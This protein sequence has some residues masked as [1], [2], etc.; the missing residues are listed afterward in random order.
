[1]VLFKENWSRDCYMIY[2]L[3]VVT[4]GVTGVKTWKNLQASPLHYHIHI[5]EHTLVLFQQEKNYHTSSHP[6][7]AQHKICIMRECLSN[8]TEVDVKLS[9]NNNWL[10]LVSHG[11]SSGSTMQG[12]NAESCWGITVEATV[13][14]GKFCSLQIIRNLPQYLHSHISN[15][16]GIE[17][18]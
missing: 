17:L 5:S 9:W 12:W 6:C 10:L 15:R 18:P 7:T 4:H 13:M 1:M 8:L 16:L 11:N 3:T 2:F 14:K